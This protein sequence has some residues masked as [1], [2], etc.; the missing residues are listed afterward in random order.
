[1][2]IFIFDN[3]G[4]IQ[5]NALVYCLMR[6]WHLPDLPN[7]AK[8]DQWFAV[9]ALKNGETYNI[10]NSNFELT[11]LMM[12]AEDGRLVKSHRVNL[13]LAPKIDGFE[14]EELK[15]QAFDI[16]LWEQTNQQAFPYA[17]MFESSRIGQRYSASSAEAKASVLNSSSNNI[18]YNKIREQVKPKPCNCGKTRVIS[19]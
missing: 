17:S 11:A 15:R 6:V 13:S 10:I 7:I 19:K 5:F 2:S 8:E 1:M 3:P 18:V 4:N 16:P 9:P 14:L 12:V